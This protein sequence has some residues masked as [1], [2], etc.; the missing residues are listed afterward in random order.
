MRQ[1]QTSIVCAACGKLVGV[2]EAACPYCGAWRPGLFGWAPTLRQLVGQRVDLV[3]LILMA[4]ITLYAVALLLEPEAIMRSQGGMLSMLSPGQRALYQLGM[5][6]GDAWALGW[7]WTVLTATYLHGGLLHIVFNMMW[8]WNLAP[9]AAEAY[10]PARAFVLFNISGIGGFLVSNALSGVPT[11]GASGAVFGLLAALIV[12]GRRL[13]QFRMAARLWQ[14]AL[15]LG[16]FGLLMPHVNNWA[17]AGGFAAGWAGAAL[18]GVREAHRESAGII[19]AAGLL[20]A[21][22]VIGVG[23]SFVSATRLFLG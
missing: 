13:G 8:V 11:V 17:H 7:W 16:V 3:S 10:G 1:R 18:M 23:L 19:L 4:C 9:A 21:G 22:T 20:I 5:T 14:W 12:A 6:S 15:I 2:S